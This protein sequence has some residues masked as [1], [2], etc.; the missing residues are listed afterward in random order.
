MEISTIIGLL[1]AFGAYGGSIMING[2]SVASLI[3]V[4]S[5]IMVVGGSIGATLIAYPLKTFLTL[6]TLFMQ[7]FQAP[8]TNPQLVIEMFVGLAD[9]ARREGL[10]SLEEQVGSIEDAFVK[11]GIM[12]IVDG[13]D[14]SVVRDILETDNDLVSRRHSSGVAMLE[15][16]G[17]VSPA[18]GML[19]TVTGLIGVL[20]NLSDTASLGPSMALAFITTLYGVILSNLFFNPVASKL[21]QKDKGEMVAREVVVEGILAIQAGENPRIVREKLESFLQPKLRGQETAE[22]G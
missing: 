4:S 3:D 7:S 6:P 17:S 5:I 1:A 9:Q 2:G 13:V 19:G 8:K 14:P 15:F 21:R 11:K 12:L 10:L 16:M 18:M 22:Q 20:G